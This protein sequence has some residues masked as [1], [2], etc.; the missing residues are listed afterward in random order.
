MRTCGR[1]GGQTSG[2]AAWRTIV[3]AEPSS[4]ESSDKSSSSLSGADFAIFTHRNL[5]GDKRRRRA[6]G[7]VR[8]DDN[9]LSALGVGVVV[10]VAVVDR[11][12]RAR[13]RARDNERATARERVD[14]SRRA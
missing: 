8:V 6:T 7:V 1:A 4:G 10:V 5:D 11:D 14:L 12:T 13:Q 3:I 9:A 2:R